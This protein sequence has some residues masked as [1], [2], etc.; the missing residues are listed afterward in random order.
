MVT[1]AHLELRDLADG[2]HLCVALGLTT[3]AATR[4]TDAVAALLVVAAWHAGHHRPAATLAATTLGSAA[5]SAY[6]L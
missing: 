3:P 6:L 2:W 4:L 1:V 5:V